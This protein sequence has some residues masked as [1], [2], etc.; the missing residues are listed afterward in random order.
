MKQRICVK[1]KEPLKRQRTFHIRAKTI[2]PFKTRWCNGPKDTPMPEPRLGRPRQARHFRLWGSDGKTMCGLQ[3]G[4]GGKY[5]WPKE[6][7]DVS[8]NRV[9]VKLDD[10][11]C[12][13]CLLLV[14]K[15]AKKQ[16]R[17]RLKAINKSALT[18]AR[19]ARKLVIMQGLKA[20]VN[21]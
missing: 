8:F 10:V 7:F 12:E 14:V 9:T 4:R 5:K 16:L 11:T 21:V 15:V 6:G 18:T 20:L 1:C 2:L 17:T 3:A 19:E 13:H